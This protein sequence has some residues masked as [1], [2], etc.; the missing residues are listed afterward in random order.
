MDGKK[1]RKTQLMKITFG[2]ILSLVIAVAYVLAAIPAVG[3]DAIMACIA[4]ALPLVLIWFPDE[5]GTF[6][7]FVRGGYIDQHS[8]AI[9]VSMMG[10][11]FLVGFPVLLWFIWR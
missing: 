5:C 9:L 6:T 7:G 1:R 4:V 10:W 2:K 11:F 8:P 3:G